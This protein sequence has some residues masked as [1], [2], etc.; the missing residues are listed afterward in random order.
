MGEEFQIEKGVGG[1]TPRH[2]NKKGQSLQLMKK[3]NKVKGP[4]PENLLFLHFRAL[5]PR[6]D[7]LGIYVLLLAKDLSSSFLG[8]Q[9]LALDAV[10]FIY[11][12]KE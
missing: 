12:S 11:C 7:I 6:K 3:R 5:W 10:N 1:Q 4:A 2:S 8:K 9:I